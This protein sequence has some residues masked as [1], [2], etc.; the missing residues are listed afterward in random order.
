[1]SNKLLTKSDITVT[2]L[3]TYNVAAKISWHRYGTKLRHCRP[4][5]LCIICAC[6]FSSFIFFRKQALRRFLPH[7]R[8]TLHR[9]AALVLTEKLLYKSLFT[10]KSAAAQKHS[11]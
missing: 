8:K 10:E 2:T 1:M 7:I 4:L 3:M 5:L 9:D 11:K 6:N